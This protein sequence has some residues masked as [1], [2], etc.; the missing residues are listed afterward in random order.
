MILSSKLLLS[1][2][3]QT[4]HFSFKE[5]MTDF[6]TVVNSVCLKQGNIKMQTSYSSNKHFFVAMTLTVCS[7][8]CIFI[9]YTHM[10]CYITVHSVDSTFP[11]SLVSNDRT[12][13]IFVSQ[14]IGTRNYNN[15]GNEKHDRCNDGIDEIV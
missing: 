8:Y 14:T 9:I 6:F 15:N 3:I 4:S 1:V 11:S 13:E 12:I 7:A 5:K 2:T 10:Q